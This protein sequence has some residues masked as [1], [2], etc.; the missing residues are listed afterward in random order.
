[1]KT[2]ETPSSIN[3]LKIYNA[4]FCLEYGMNP[5]DFDAEL[6]LYQSDDVKIELANPEEILEIMGKIIYFDKRIEQLKIGG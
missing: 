1:L 3:Q 6:R 2:G 5:K 4:L